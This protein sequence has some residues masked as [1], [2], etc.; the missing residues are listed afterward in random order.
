MFV[1]WDDNKKKSNIT[2]SNFKE[3]IATPTQFCA[4]S[5][6]DRE[7][8]LTSFN[9]K[10]Y[11]YVLEYTYNKAV[12]VL[13]DT[14]FSMGE[15]LVVGIIHWID[16]AVISNFFDIF[17]LRLAY[18]L[19][20][21][22]IEQKLAMIEIIEYLQSKK[23][24]FCE[25]E[26]LDKEKTK[27]FI[28]QLYDG[29]LTKDYS[30]F[31]NKMAR[32]LDDLQTKN[33]LLDSDEYNEM[34][35]LTNNHKNL[36]LRILF[37]L[38]KAEINDSKKNKIVIQNMKNLIVELW[39]KASLN[40]KKFYSYY[41][42]TIP[43]DSSVGKAFAFIFEDIKIN[44][45]MTD[46]SVVTN[47]LKACQNILSSHYSLSN[48]KDEVLGLIK[49]SEIKNYPKFFLR[50]VITPSL[51]TYIGNN[52][53]VNSEARE[54]AESI[55]SQIS[56]EKWT[57]Y[58][59]NFFEA[60]DF[61]LINL[62][63]VPT[64]LKDFCSLIKKAGVVEDDIDNVDIKNLLLACKKGDFDTITTIAHNLVLNQ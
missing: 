19:D 4:L 14:I 18:D 21:I 59:K 39:D 52:N 24:T 55:L 10:M 37:S 23:E 34:I 57:Y 63:T 25:S 5:E 1:T 3:I 58:F 15:E 26:D 40:E 11:N 9:A 56:S 16:R 2:D 49:L 53:G 30:C 7:F 38:V 62:C 47:I 43:T 42:K 64:C 61:V 29:I 35:A 20:L 33:I 22:T 17:V 32:L 46:L 13:Q 6:E 60:D 28:M 50:S 51:L 12:K 8:L 36:L 44:D 45:F 48:Q 54:Y 31:V 27:Y 41:L